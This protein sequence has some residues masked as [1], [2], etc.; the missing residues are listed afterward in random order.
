MGKANNTAPLGCI[1]VPDSAGM[2]SGRQLL[3]FIQGKKEGMRKWGTAKR[4][5]RDPSRVGDECAWLHGFL[6]PPQGS[7]SRKEG[8]LH[9]PCLTVPGQA[10]DTHR[11]LR[12]YP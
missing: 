10:W 11:C 6:G 2:G 12:P 5:L 9:H 8:T 7:S 4:V 1:S 3:P